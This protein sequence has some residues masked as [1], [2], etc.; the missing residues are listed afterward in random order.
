[1]WEWLEKPH[2]SAISVSD[3]EGSTSS[4]R[5][6]STRRCRTYLCGVCPVAARNIREKWMGLY[7]LSLANASRV[8]SF[9]RSRMRSST[10]LIACRGRAAGAGTDARIYSLPRREADM[11]FRITPFDEPEVISRRLLHMPYCMGR[12]GR[13]LR[14]P[15][16]ERAHA[17]DHD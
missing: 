7:P 6:R 5:A 2:S 1:M 15:A 17:G 12:S 4:W 8:R 13:N 3:T 16:M 9:S 11:V 10:R 14:A